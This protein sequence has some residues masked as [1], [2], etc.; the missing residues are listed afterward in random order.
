MK[1]LPLW[2]TLFVGVALAIMIALGIWQ[3]KRATWK[4]AL[5]AR[6]AAAETLPPIAFP[7]VP[8]PDESL[9]FRRASGTCREVTEWNA[10]A[11][12]NRQGRSGWRHIARCRTGGAEGPGMTVDLGWSAS[13]DAPRSYSGGPVSGIMD[14][15]RDHVFVLVAD[16]P[17]PGLEPS[18]RPSPAKISNNHRAYAVQWFLF[19]I[20]ALVIYIAALRRRPA[21]NPPADPPEARH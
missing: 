16:N 9:L 20:V 7:A 10:R 11:G 1:R 18:A 21:A 12:L 14:F 2:P 13:S 19:A 17:A 3:L 4:E 15:D 5:L 6:Y 8:V